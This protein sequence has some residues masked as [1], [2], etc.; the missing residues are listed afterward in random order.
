[1]TRLTTLLKP[2]L[3]EAS[4]Y[5]ER[6]AYSM[7]FSSQ[8][9]ISPLSLNE[10]AAS[11]LDIN[12]RAHSEKRQMLKFHKWEKDISAVPLGLHSTIYH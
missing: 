12:C 4:G 1:M 3:N 5:T 9:S 2:I 10:G 6:A 8:W 7:L 11:E